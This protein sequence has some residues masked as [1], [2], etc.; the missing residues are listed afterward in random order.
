MT[1]LVTP[2]PATIS[3]VLAGNLAALAE[4]SPRIAEAIRQARP[5]DNLNWSTTDQPG[6]WSAE[7]DGRALASRRRP[8]DEAERLAETVDFK[9]AG[10]VAVLG[11]GL[12]YHVASLVK[13][14]GP[15]SVVIVFEPDL[16]LL[17]T[18]MERADYGPWL[19]GGNVFFFHNPDDAAAL[20]ES[21]RGMEGLLSIGV[22]ILEHAPSKA[23][24]GAAAT[25]FAEALT[26][27]VASTRTQVITTMMQME[28]TIRNLLMNSD[29][30]C[31][32]DGIKDLAG[33]AKGRA[34]VIISAGPSLERN[35]DLL[36]QPGVRDRVVLIA[37]QTVLKPLLRRG[38]RP[39]FVTALDYHEV[40]TRFYEGLTKA[41]VE[42]IT[43]I[44][45]PKAN[46]AILDA[47][48]GTRRL[49]GS[50][51][52][53]L[54]LGPSLAGEHGELPAGATVAH[55]AYY[56]AR[57]LGCDP[58]LLVGQ[59]LAFTDGQYYSA[60]AAIHDVWANELNP[61][62]TL[63]MMEWQRIVR[64]RGHLHSRID[65]H[66]RKVYTDD[67][68]ATYL[69]QFE[70]DFLADSER[71]L[72]IIDATE[73]GARKAH[74]TIMPLVEALAKYAPISQDPLAFPEPSHAPLPKEVMKKHF[75]A[76]HED[77][78]KIAYLAR[79]AGSL[80]ESM[81]KVQ[82][83]TPRI[84]R[85]IEQTGTLRERVEKLQPAYG[86]VH[87]LNQAGAFKRFRA[88]RILELEEGLTP[89][90]HQERQIRR[91]MMNVGWLAEAADSL[92]DL[93]GATIAM[94]DGAPKRTRDPSA[95]AAGR[96]AGEQSAAPVRI[97][98]V[99]PL[100]AAKCGID[101]ALLRSTLTRLRSCDGLDQIFILA[102]DPAAA[103]SL[104][105]SCGD[106]STV[107][108]LP[109][110]PAL[111]ER[112]ADSIAAARAWAGASWRGGLG[113]LTCYDEVFSPAAVAQ[114]LEQQ[115]FDA[116]LLVGPD[117]S[118]IDASLCEQVIARHRESPA[119]LP[120]VFTQAPPGLAGCV[121]SAK[122]C[123]EMAQGRA[124][125]DHF[126]TLGGMLGYRPTRARPDAIVQPCC[127]P[128]DST[129]RSSPWR[130]IADQDSSLSLARAPM[131]Q[132]SADLIRAMDGAVGAA[133]LHLLLEL[134]TERATTPNT[135]PLTVITRDSAFAI[136]DQFAAMS[137]RAG[138]TFGGRGDPLLHPDLPAII[139]HAKSRGLM[140]HVRTEALASPEAV[141]LLIEAQ[142]HVISID[143]HAVRAETYTALTGTTRMDE[144]LRNVE[145]MLIASRREGRLPFPWIVPR[146]TRRD[147]T[148]QEIEGFF[149]R[150]LFFAGAC[151][152]DPL[153]SIVQGERITP[154]PKPHATLQREAMEQLTVRSTG[155][156]ISSDTDDASATVVGRI[157]PH[158]LAELWNK[159]RSE[160]C[161]NLPF[162]CTHT[163]DR[164]RAT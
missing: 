126:A 128:I 59:D 143:L 8:I 6:A 5:L 14:G 96:V 150:G 114:A 36:A 45:E 39:H 110:D 27:V 89:L 67:Q 93:I 107:E 25:R 78:K 140:V 62:N 82:H 134:T 137:P 120:F 164:A 55:L 13:R 56:F 92:Q 66:G 109:V 151:I 46:A 26:Q 18:V 63:E 130:Y 147:A 139:T 141:R 102:A 84:N 149:D 144:A 37:V 119:T 48:P 1:S 160:R 152:I 65:H 29:Q 58:V 138:I 122:L 154:L 97:A 142:P 133:P 52:L 23:R 132:T 69:A 101:P 75:R 123:R 68:M 127:V 70:R 90:E 31:A 117:W 9:E 3:P 2:T 53:D 30:Y 77:A 88:D 145:A 79:E 64:W 54:V 22:K 16:S 136:L 106:F 15:R 49:V 148:C 99:L 157:G 50:E 11:F 80:L 163:E 87:R 135:C 86:L 103:R 113:Y 47:F 146:I 91:D 33:I 34:A 38:I 35:I 85:L 115:G 153:P 17:R 98:A 21:L 118:L 7:L 76:V 4:R 116:A 95:G 28:V 83:D 162:Q 24:L 129:I 108:I 20:N 81:L 19:R 43:L 41:D 42:G 60:G 71:G 61:F 125:G 131:H 10:T 57:H 104:L 12:G 112:D 105:Q 73:G 74:T 94:L 121:V 72:T 100:S 161:N 155:E 111:L 44:A 159:A 156:V 32:G 124:A 51:M 158:S 40:S